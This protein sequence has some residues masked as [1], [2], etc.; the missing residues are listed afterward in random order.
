MDGTGNE[1]KEE[2]IDLA[3]RKQ[4]WNKMCREVCGPREYLEGTKRESERKRSWRTKCRQNMRKQA[5]NTWEC[6]WRVGERWTTY[7]MNNQKKE[8]KSA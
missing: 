8:N 2:Q 5:G 3:T 6:V 1:S 4:D 7:G